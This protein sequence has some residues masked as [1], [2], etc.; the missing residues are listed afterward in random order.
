MRQ[1]PRLNTFLRHWYGCLRAR[2]IRVRGVYATKDTFV[3]TA[4]RVGVRIPWLEAQTGVSYA[5]LR[6]HYGEW[7]P[8]EDRAEFER[9]TS[10]APDVVGDETHQIGPCVKGLS[11]PISE[12]VKRRKNAR[13]GTRTRFHTS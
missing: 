3:T 6:R 9:F 12:N 8:G 1:E 7:M 2:G 5:T 13:G 10:L 4:L 11:G